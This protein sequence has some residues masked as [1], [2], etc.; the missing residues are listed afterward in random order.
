M[1]IYIYWRSF[2]AYLCGPRKDNRHMAY[3]RSG[4]AYYSACGGQ[5]AV[6]RRCTKI[7]LTGVWYAAIYKIRHSAKPAATSIIECCF[8]KS[9]EMLISHAI[10]N[11]RYFTDFL[12]LKRLECRTAKS[13]A[14]ALET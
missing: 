3:V 4:G 7:L 2:Y 6:D 5:A 9:V 11:E 14:S 1:S 8:I 13:V 10:I 12:S